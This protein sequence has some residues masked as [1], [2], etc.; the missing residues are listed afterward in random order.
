MKQKL[1]S[2]IQ[3]ITGSKAQTTNGLRN[4]IERNGNK[5]AEKLLDKILKIE[6]KED[7]ARIRAIRID[8]A[9]SFKMSLKR[10]LRLRDKLINSLSFMISQGYIR[11]G[12]K[13]N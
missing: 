4:A 10:Y 8:N 13:Q 1:I 3:E 9:K 2:Q 12:K 11:K 7:A 5:K 6:V